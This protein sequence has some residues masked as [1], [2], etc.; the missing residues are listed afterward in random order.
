LSTSRPW[1]NSASPDFTPR[2]LARDADFS[3]EM[4][5]ARASRRRLEAGFMLAPLFSRKR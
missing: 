2:F 3:G 5:H 4:T 1:E